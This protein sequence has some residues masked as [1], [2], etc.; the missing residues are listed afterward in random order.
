MGE[1][2][3][4]QMGGGSDRKWPKSSGDFSMKTVSWENGW[5]DRLCVMR[6]DLTKCISHSKTFDGHVCSCDIEARQHT[7]KHT[8]AL[9][10]FIGL[11]VFSSLARSWEVTRDETWLQA[12]LKSSHT[13]TSPKACS[14]VHQ[15][16]ISVFI[17]VC[18]AVS[19]LGVGVWDKAFV[20]DAMPNVLERMSRT[21][22][23]DVLPCWL[24]PSCGGDW[25]GRHHVN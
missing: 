10:S 19:S 8:L 4:G 7:R 17:C 25:T 5:R 9:P 12:V 2:E 11:I 1:K 16:Y 14:W 6:A 13:Y 18:S 24:E 22:G 3:G 20:S 21:L 23:C 15:Q